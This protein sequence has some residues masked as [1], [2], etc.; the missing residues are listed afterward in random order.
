MLRLF[1]GIVTRRWLAIVLALIVLAG[2][3]WNMLHLAID[4]VPDI[5]PKQ[6]MILTQANGLGPLEVERLVTAPIEMQV[7]GL[8]GLSGVRSKSSFGLSAVYVALN[9][10]V[11]VDTAR[12]RIFESLQV[13]QATMPPGVGTPEEGPLATGLGEILEFELLGPGYTQMQLYQML[14]WKIVPQLR[15]VPGIV[16]VNIYGGDL[17]TYEIS[18][19]PQKLRARAVSLP[20]LFSAIESNNVAR[21]GAYIEH[22]DEQQVVRGMAMVQSRDDIAEIVVRATQGGIPV[23]VGDL[24]TVVL[25]PKVRLGAVTHDGKGDL[26][27]SPCLF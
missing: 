14:K 6:V 9:D 10:G 20:E 4:A 22:G 24:G 21:G 27:R 11:D 18:V 12:A 19:D 8:P 17:Q 26:P 13:A 15:L 1:S 16:N 2:G 25:A 23:T 3:I 7:T 5:S